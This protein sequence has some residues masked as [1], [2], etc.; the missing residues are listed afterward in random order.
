MRLLITGANGLLGQKLVTLIA[1]RTDVELIATSRGESKI[2]YDLPT[3]QYRSLD[4]TQPAEVDEV[5]GQEKPDVIIHTAALTKVDYC[6]H[7]RELC[8][9]LNVRAVDYVVQAAVKHNCLLIHLST[10][11]IFSGDKRL[12]TE[13]DLPGPINYYGQTKLEAEQRIIESGVKYAIARTAIVYGVVPHLSR[14]NIILWVK[15]SLKRGK[16]IHVVDDQFR[17]PTLAED[18]AMGCFL[19]AQ[20]QASG[21]FNVSGEELLT[22]YQM[23]Q[24]TADY[25]ELDKQLIVRTDSTKFKQ[26][27]RRPLETGFVID[28]AKRVLDYQPHT[29]LQGVQLL[30]EQLREI[31]ALA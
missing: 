30:D 9:L 5:I 4:V 11:F 10:D 15:E 14:S 13:E 2:H 7:H 20:E 21:I 3:Y 27:A 1:P 16:K 24:M 25:F 29:F 23:A 28:K 17:T 8:Y 18:L 12:L 19:I 6:E 31:N 22:P 26:P